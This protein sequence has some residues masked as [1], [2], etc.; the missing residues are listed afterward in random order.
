MESEAAGGKVSLVASELARAA[1]EVADVARASLSSADEQDTSGA[2]L[3]L[4]AR[5]QSELSPSCT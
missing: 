1:T 4:E 3:G 2:I 5:E